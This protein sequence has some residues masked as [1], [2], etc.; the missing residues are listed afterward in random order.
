MLTDLGALH[1]QSPRNVGPLEGP[2]AYGVSGVPGDGPYVEIWAEVADGV[3]RRAAYRTYGCPSSVA[4]A[5]VLCELAIGR[6]ASRVASL[7]AGDLLAVLG[8][9]PEGKGHLAAMAVE[10]MKA[11]LAVDR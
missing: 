11:A 6:D 2:C 8:G 3:V 1:V 5:S 4:A 7:E 9:L 10:A